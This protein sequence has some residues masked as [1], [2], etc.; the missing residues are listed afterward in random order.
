MFL[1]LLQKCFLRHQLW[2]S[3]LFVNQ[4]HLRNVP[5]VHVTNDLLE[6]PV[7]HEGLHEVVDALLVHLLLREFGLIRV[8]LKVW[9]LVLVH[10]VFLRDHARQ[11]DQRELLGASH[12]KLA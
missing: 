2:Q 10:A 7:E 3:F 6:S 12:A 11:M 1:N 8:E 9:P 5:L 4:I